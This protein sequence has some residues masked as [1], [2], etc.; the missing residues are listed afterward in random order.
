[1]K[2]FDSFVFLK[3]RCAKIDTTVEVGKGQ[4]DDKAVRD[5]FY[6][7]LGTDYERP[8]QYEWKVVCL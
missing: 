3:R 6:M 4:S 1:M 8:I 2:I 7:R 5:D